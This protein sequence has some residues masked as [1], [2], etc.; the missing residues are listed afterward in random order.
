MRLA[1]RAHFVVINVPDNLRGVPVFHDGLPEAM[2]WF[3][4]RPGKELQIAAFQNLQSPWD[5]VV[6]SGQASLSMR[7][8][9]P[10]DTFTRISPAQCLQISNPAND[11]LSIYPQSCASS[12]DVFFLSGGRMNKLKLTHD[13]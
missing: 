2:Q 5:E 13:E 6:I 1:P 12:I 8:L 4:D 10:S 11:T 7:A 9:N 3:Q